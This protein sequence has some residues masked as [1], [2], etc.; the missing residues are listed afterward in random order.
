MGF[1]ASSQLSQRRSA[2]NE[3]VFGY[4]PVGFGRLCSVC[5]HLKSSRLDSASAETHLFQSRSTRA[6]A[7]RQAAA[8]PCSIKSAAVLRSSSEFS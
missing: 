7:D 8:E 5:S 1:G 6:E 4:A 2:A 3:S